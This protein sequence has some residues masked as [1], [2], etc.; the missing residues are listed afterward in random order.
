MCKESQTNIDNNLVLYYGMPNRLVIRKQGASFLKI[1][2]CLFGGAQLTLY[3][4]TYV[5]DSQETKWTGNR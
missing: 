2:H 3:T 4:P 5:Y 1:Q